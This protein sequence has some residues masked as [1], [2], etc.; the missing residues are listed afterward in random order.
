MDQEHGIA[1]K[2]LI[3]GR[4]AREMME[5]RRAP[6]VAN[7]MGTVTRTREATGAKGKGKGKGKGKSETRHCYDCGEQGHFGVNCPY[8]WAN[9]IH[10]EDDQ[11]SS[12]EIEPEGENAEELASMETH[13]EE[14]ECC[15][16]WKG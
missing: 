15:W 13:D 6:R 16:T 1:G 10:E 4:A 9:S 7:L 12:W 5:G 8:R 11:A 2:E 3:N 14:G